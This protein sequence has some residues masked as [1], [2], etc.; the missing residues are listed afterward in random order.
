MF[1][2][3]LLI[4]ICLVLMGCSLTS[5]VEHA[6][7]IAGTGKLQYQEFQTTDFTLAGYVRVAKRDAPINIYI[8]GDGFAW[9]D[10][11]TP[12]PDPTPKNPLALSLA[13]QDNSANVIYLARPCQFV[14]QPYCQQK[15]WTTHRFALEVIEAMNAVL[16][17]I[18]DQYPSNAFHVIGYS[19]GG[20]IAALLAARRDDVQ[21]LRTVAGNMDHVAFNRHHNVDQMPQ[22]LNAADIA[23]KI[24]HIPQH[25]FVGGKDRV[26]PKNV[27]DSYLAKAGQGGC[28]NTTVVKGATHQEG[29]QTHWPQILQPITCL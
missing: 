21:S 5:R 18:K 3:V 6:S 27:L 20:N 11:R 12:S 4:C 17:E 23:E 15:Y 13:A 19:G 7:S 8:E 25:H 1:H 28:I 24:K 10:R 9:L 22:S 29:W 14:K 2:R 16:D 26:V